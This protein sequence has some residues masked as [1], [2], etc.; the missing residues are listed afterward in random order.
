VVFLPSLRNDFTNWDDSIY[1]YE[2]PD[3]RNLDLPGLA[4]IFSLQTR[5]AEDWTP[6][7]TFTH[8][9]EYRLV[10]L[11]PPV[12]HATNVLLHVAATLV[13]FALLLRVGVPLF[14]AFAGALVF[15]IHPLQV[16][17]VVWVSG[18]KNVLS[19]LFGFAAALV[20]LKG[21]RRAYWGALTLFVLSCLS[22]GIAI[23]VP[24]LIVAT[25]WSARQGVPW[26]REAL[27]LAPF[28]LV[29]VGRGLM[30]V[31]SQSD[32]WA[33]TA[34]VPFDD[35]MAIMGGVLLSYLRQLVVPTDLR[36]FYSWPLLSWTDPLPLAGYGLVL[37]LTGLVVWRLRRNPWIAYL[38]AFVP[39][40]LGPMLNVFPA[41]FFQADRY[42]YMSLPAAGALVAGAVYLIAERLRSAWLT[43]VC[44]ALWCGFVLTPA[45]LRQIP[46]WEDS[47]TLWTYTLKY[48][49]T[50]HIAYN[51][52]G[53]WYQNQEDFETAISHYEQ[54]LVI[55][56]KFFEARVNLGM[57]FYQTD[58]LPEAETL[59]R[60][61]LA[62]ESDR[63]RANHGL[64]G[65]RSRRPRRTTGGRSICD[66]STPRP[67]RI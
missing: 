10:L 46:V 4:Q 67:S 54:S 49:P 13:V 27:K 60:Q 22:K 56:P 65:E 48:E 12:Y 37:V 58:R 64:D 14:V 41:P 5:T 24:P 33:R 19:G 32:V 29:A 44:L 62:E 23:V 50:F 35:R 38:G 31:G 34:A 18:R 39:I 28:F 16:E 26:R 42:V 1:V 20:Y 36:T 43:P 53:L 11:E 21:T 63:P 30:T 55:R 8:A 45:T 15:G 47:Y 52:L 66:P 57:A 59:F 51:N 6:L 40:T 61:V 7:V 2:N 3:I 9:I 25:L 17:S